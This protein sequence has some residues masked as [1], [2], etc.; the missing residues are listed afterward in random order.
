MK[1]SVCMM[2]YNHAPYVAEAIESVLM[3]ETDFDYELIIGEDDSSDGTRQ[4]AEAYAQQYPEKI[5]LFLN[6]GIH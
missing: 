4:I 6:D 2:A 3:Q 5:R 1:V